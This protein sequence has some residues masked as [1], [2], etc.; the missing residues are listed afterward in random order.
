M[1]DWETVTELSLEIVENR[2]VDLSKLSLRILT[3]LLFNINAN[4]GEN[5]NF[6]E[7]LEGEM[8]GQLESLLQY[9]GAILQ[10]LNSGKQSPGLC[11]AKRELFRNLLI[12]RHLD[13]TPELDFVPFPF[14]SSMRV[15]GLVPSSMRMF[16]SQVYP[17][18]IELLVQNINDV[19]SQWVV[20]KSGDD[21][22]R[23]QQV[24][25][26]ISFMNNVLKTNGINLRTVVLRILAITPTEGIMNFIE[27]GLTIANITSGYGSIINYFRSLTSDPIKLST[28][29]NT[30]ALSAA[31]GCVITYIL[32]ISDRH[33]ENMLVTSAAQLLHID[34]G[35]VRGRTVIPRRPTFRLSSEMVEAMGGDRSSHFALFEQACRDSFLC[36]RKRHRDVLALL[37]LMQ[38]SSPTTA[39]ANSWWAA[40]ITHSF[41]LALSEEEAGAHFLRLIPAAR[42]ELLPWITDNVFH[43]LRAAFR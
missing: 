3:L 10:C 42:A 19:N 21:L 17:C 11:E 43:P 33:P 30:F 35:S 28:M 37:Q 25:T 18:C 39:T 14:D 38:R 16:R 26:L 15:I 34:Y 31:A 8:R 29:M 24:S 32:G 27:D 2:R 9:F 20:I 36:L 1:E 23:E 13:R 4:Y 7:C 22:R 5:V 40:H 6:F 12:D 41:Q